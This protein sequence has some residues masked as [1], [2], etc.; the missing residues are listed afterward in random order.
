MFRQGESGNPKGRP[1][2]ATNKVA[3]PIKEQLSDFL[4]AKIQELPEIWSKLSPRDKARFITDLIP[5]FVARL[6][7]ISVGVEF[8]QLND[9]QLNYIID[10]LLNKDGKN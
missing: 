1:Q 4:T 9:S 10:T 5:Y 8:D 2:G 3:R 7:S 6:Q